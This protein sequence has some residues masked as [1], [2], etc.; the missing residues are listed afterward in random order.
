MLFVVGCQIWFIF[1]ILL[2]ESFLNSDCA[3]N[4]FFAPEKALIASA[5][6][7]SGAICYANQ[8]YVDLRKLIIL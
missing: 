8:S 4:G 1:A 5:F 3:S 6:L 2:R 7:C